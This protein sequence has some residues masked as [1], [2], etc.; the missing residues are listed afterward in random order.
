MNIHCVGYLY[1]EEISLNQLIL[2]IQN[3]V[4]KTS[5]TDLSILQFDVWTNFSRSVFRN[6][7]LC[8]HNCYLKFPSSF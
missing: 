8:F 1:V 3:P 5:A 2:S 7:I 6:E 4:E